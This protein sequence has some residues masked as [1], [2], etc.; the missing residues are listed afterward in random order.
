MAWDEYVETTEREDREHAF[1][2]T[3]SDCGALYSNL[4]GDCPSCESAN[5]SYDPGAVREW[6]D[7]MRRT[8][9]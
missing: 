1:E 3:C 6:T 5:C 2:V 4:D 9:R 7:Y 8:G